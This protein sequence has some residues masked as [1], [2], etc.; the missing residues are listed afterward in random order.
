IVNLLKTGSAFYA[1]S[2]AVVAMV[3]A[4]MYDKHQVLACIAYL[5]GEYGLKGVYAGV[6]VKLGAQGIEEIVQFKLSDDEMAALRK[7]GDAVR[8]LNKVMGI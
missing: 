2:A 7:S 1:P 4:I 5:E 6:P 3:D 8:A